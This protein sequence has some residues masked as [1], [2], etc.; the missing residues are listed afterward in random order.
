VFVPV[1]ALLPG[2]LGLQWIAADLLQ[3]NTHMLVYQTFYTEFLQRIYSFTG[4]IKISLLVSIKH[5]VSILVTF[6]K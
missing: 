2:S 4:F 1:T 5:A 6:R 3:G